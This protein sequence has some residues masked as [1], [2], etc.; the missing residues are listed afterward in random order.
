M[1]LNRTPG[2]FEAKYTLSGTQLGEGSY[3]K[4]NLGINKASGEKVA[5]KILDKKKMK[6]K[7]IKKVQRE[8]TILSSLFH[9]NVVKVYDSYEDLEREVFY[10]VM[11]FASKGNLFDQI[12]DDTKDFTE[13]EAQNILR[14]LVHALEYCKSKG[15]VHRDLKPDNILIAE[16]GLLKIA[17]FNLSKMLSTYEMEFSVLETQCGTP[18]YVAPEV[19]SG[20]PY[21]YK[22]DVWSLGVILYLLLSGGYLPF[23]PE[24]S[25]STNAQSDLL[26][27]IR[28]GKWD[29]EPEENWRYISDDAKD[30]LAKMLTKNPKNRISYT[31]ILAHPWLAIKKQG[32][33]GHLARVIDTSSLTILK[34]KV[35]EMNAQTKKKFKSSG[36]T[37]V[38]ASTLASLMGPETEDGAPPPTNSKSGGSNLF[39]I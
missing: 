11:E 31:E 20:K 22:C 2:A 29:F 16:K 36:A 39:T 19:I 27:K 3:A 30:L 13:E 24:D 26:K 14:P 28:A 6:K 12:V 34:Q 32:S 5:V 1:T 37:F 9:K 23:F 18:N 21:D 17:D 8:V 33:S 25:R 7:D 10:I 35:D 4:V 38:A 15:V